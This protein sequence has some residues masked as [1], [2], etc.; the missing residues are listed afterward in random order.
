M[1]YLKPNITL[2]FLGNDLPSG[3][4]LVQ[5]ITN[6]DIVY[7]GIQFKYQLLDG[8]KSSSNQVMLQL[9]RTCSSIEDII[10]TD[11]D[12]KAVLKD[13]STT[14]FTGYIS[15]NFSWSVT[16][17]G[18]QALNI[19]I[20]D[21]GTRLLGKPYLKSG[22]MLFNCT[23]DTAIRNICNAAG[24][25][26]SPACR[27]INAPVIKVVESG[28]SCKEILSQL[29]YELGY[30][31]FFD[32]E[33][34]LL[35]FK[36]DCTTTEGAT[37]ID[38][39]KLYTYSGKAISLTKDIKQ[40]KSA[41]ITYTRIAEATDF[42]VYRNT[43]GQDSDHGYC[44]MEMGPLTYFDGTEIYTNEQWREETE[45][46]FRV[47]ARIEVC[48]AE[49][50]TDIVGSSK[51][52]NVSNV[53]MTLTS[54]GNV[55]KSVTAS[56]GPYLEMLVHN[57]D[58]VIRHVTRMD[59]HGTIL[60]EKDSNIVRTAD[61]AID[62]ASS[63]NLL[64]E[65]LEF[66]HD[67][68]L[69]QEHANLIGQYHRYCNSRYAFQSKENLELGSIIRLKDNVFSGL[70]VYVFLTA[71]SLNDKSDI[72]QYTAIGISVFD[73]DAE[74]YKQKAM[75]GTSTGAKGEKGEPGPQGPP[76][77]SVTITAI[78]YGKSSSRSTRPT[79]WTTT[80]PSVEGG[81]YLWTRCTFSDGSV[82]LSYSYQALDADSFTTSYEYASSDS[83]TSAP[84]SGWSNTAYSSW[85]KG[86]YVWTRLVKTYPDGTVE[87]E[88]PFYN[89]EL[90][91]EFLAT[92]VF[93]FT[94][95]R[96]TYIRDLRHGGNT[97][98]TLRSRIVG[99]GAVQITFS[100]SAGT[101][102]GNVLTIPYDISDDSITVTMSSSNGIVSESADITLTVNDITIPSVYLGAFSSAPSDAGEYGSLLEGDHYLNT[103]DKYPYVYLDGSWTIVSSSTD[104]YQQ[105]LLNCM[106][107]VFSL[108]NVPDSVLAYYAYFENVIARYIGTQ[109]IMLLNGEDGALGKFHSDGYEQGTV[110]KLIAGILDPTTTKK[111]F[112]QDSDGN[113][114]FFKADIYQAT[115]NKG[116]INNAEIVKGTITDASIVGDLNSE[117]FSTLKS[118]SVSNNYR[119]KSITE[120][121][122]YWYEKDAVS[123]LSSV[124][125]QTVVSQ[126]GTYEN[127]SFTGLIK[128]T[129]A[130]RS[131]E[132][133]AASDQAI[134]DTRTISG[135]PI[136]RTNTL[137]FSGVGLKRK[138]ET[139]TGI[140]TSNGRMY[141]SLDNSTWNL[142]SSAVSGLSAE[143]DQ[144]VYAKQTIDYD[145]QGY[146]FSEKTLNSSLAAAL[147]GVDYIYYPLGI[148]ANHYVI[149]GD[150]KYGIY[151]S[152][153]GDTWTRISIDYCRDPAGMAYG[154]GKL[155]ILDS[156]YDS[157]SSQ[158]TVFVS[159]DYGASFTRYRPMEYYAK[160]TYFHTLYFIGGYFYA[161]SGNL[162]AFTN[163]WRSSDGVN[164]SR[165]SISIGVSALWRSGS[166]LYGLTNS[167]SSNIYS[168]TDG[169]NWTERYPLG[170]TLSSSYYY[171]FACTQE[172][173]IIKQYSRYYAHDTNFY[174]STDNGQT[175]QT[176]EESYGG[177]SNCCEYLF[178]DAVQHFSFDQN[179]YISKA[180]A[181]TL[182]DYTIQTPGE[183]KISYDLTSY[184][185]GVNF[186]NAGYLPIHRISMAS[187][188]FVDYSLVITNLF[189]SSSAVKYYHPRGMEYY[190]SSTS[191][192]V[193]EAENEF[194][195]F[196][197]I[198]CSYTI[199][200]DSGNAQSYSLTNI[201]S[202]K[203]DSSGITVIVNRV[204]IYS[205]P[206]SAWLSALNLTFTPIG[207]LRGN[208]TES[209]F[210]EETSVERS[211]EINLGSEAARFDNAF[212]DKIG[213]STCPVA[214]I[215]VNTLTGEKVYGAYWNDIADAIEVD[216]K[217]TLI[218]G[219]CYVQ[220]NNKVCLSSKH[221]EEGII[222]IH[223]D[224]Y[225]FLLGQK[226]KHK[227]LHIA[228]GGF[229][230]ACVDKAYRPGTPL[231]CSV[232]G[233]L[234][235]M[236]LLQ[237]ILHP[238]R[239]VGVFHQQE[240]GSLWQGIKVDG[241]H[242]VKVR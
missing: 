239:M 209:I 55:S 190:N 84:V 108:T 132:R 104:S 116:N 241:R 192:W 71:K 3:H 135:S 181:V 138:C 117:T 166:T 12:V 1:E 28:K 202:V 14:L 62:S 172:L 45:D 194:I 69:A 120:G 97:S 134:S 142:F 215:N 232:G 101:V 10:A 229:V 140:H 29:L 210:P 37:L 178:C 199:I 39:S 73:L 219:R 148:D 111:G 53:V 234:T 4:S 95:S 87:R 200:T 164:W 99:Y 6:E 16:E 83:S 34:R 109:D 48:N 167:V 61:T 201:T 118:D 160:S 19:T 173:L 49:S 112:F 191:A 124:P 151:S 40:Y 136:L 128:L 122:A 149:L 206:S 32:T 75:A 137:S 198:A 225:G 78:E 127:S 125:E 237:R 26:V 179:G 230:L 5:T 158:P 106:K 96:N 129:E 63:D 85:Y 67:G 2:T 162:S 196:Q 213:S 139:L 107:D 81:E 42:L 52:I 163:A 175:F 170:V 94:P 155:V 92:C 133:I 76:G 60:Y 223:S 147:S 56:G 22:C 131:S 20:E 159:T 77:T 30:V 176:Y 24:I 38:R 205:I 25:T 11:G 238:E 58:S 154:N 143:K 171:Q 36:V 157:D 88:D 222:G 144:M 193:S 8:L 90:T 204:D 93:S 211:K 79:T 126:G 218:P 203:W 174:I 82:S 7:P 18:Q 114:E 17:S 89:E 169:V 208:Y 227:E 236:G 31:Y 212:I 103:T 57:E 130:Q 224:T 216:E 186:L 197:N 152:D 221:C 184:Q 66:V 141:Y 91:S 23:A 51:I 207:R 119:N 44:N 33:G 74:V 156:A 9:F 105:I 182:E 188:Q 161:W 242:W 226:G 165:V 187:P 100:A 102:S 153:G 41:K 177:V 233:K 145:L 43:T 185:E 86:L 80:I 21:T 217:V 27:V 98:V 59:V 113:A 68:L 115:M 50:R 70:D 72:I 123:S 150:D 46:E 13:G 65:T 35:V 64:E 183:L 189:D 110:A 214:S 168:S 235:R 15:T 180:R 220:R 195:K 231:T 47:P 240:K 54:D 146:K 228:V 121:S